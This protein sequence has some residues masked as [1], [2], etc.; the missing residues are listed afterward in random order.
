MPRIAQRS[1]SF[2]GCSDWQ[3]LSPS[4]EF[5]RAC[6]PFPG[7]RRK[8]RTGSVQRAGYDGAQA[9]QVWENLLGELKITGGEDVGKRSLMLAT[10]PAVA[11]RR[12]ELLKLAGNLGGK[13]GAPEYQRAIAP[14]RLGWLKDEIRRGQFEESIV[15][16]GRLLRTNPDDAQVLFARGE[17]Y[18]LR[19]GP[20][21]HQL[22]LDDLARAAS[23]DQAPADSF[24]SLG[25]V[26][27]RRSDGAAASAAFERYLS[28]APGAPDAGLIKTYLTETKP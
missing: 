21:D 10:H 6:L 16:F 8:G 14:H 24:R 11:N 18:R 4:W 12:D 3:A 13:L 9:A 7:S 23:M 1:G 27:K 17:V 22:A 25:L 2:S 5:W 26:H 28:L 15:L 19:G 20:D